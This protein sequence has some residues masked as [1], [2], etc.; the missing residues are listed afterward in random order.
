MP[1]S[2]R[3]SRDRSGPRDGGS[4]DRAKLPDGHEVDQATGVSTGAAVTTNHE[5][6]EVRGIPLATV[7]VSLA[8]MAIGLW[9][10]MGD[11]YYLQQ[12]VLEIL[13]VS[14]VALVFLLLGHAFRQRRFFLSPKNGKWGRGKDT[15][16]SSP[17]KTQNKN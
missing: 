17:L 1:S 2:Y 12:I 14:I 5:Q 9:L 8:A 15:R 16:P 6:H 7:V 13:L 3:G 10:R 4:D 11:F